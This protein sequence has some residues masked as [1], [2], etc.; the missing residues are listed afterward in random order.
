MMKAHVRAWL[1]EQNG[2]DKELLQSLYAE[3]VSAARLEAVKAAL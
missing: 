1:T 3:S 2:E